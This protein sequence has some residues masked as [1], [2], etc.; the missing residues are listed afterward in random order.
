MATVIG[1]PAP[2]DRVLP[3]CKAGPTLSAGVVAGTRR[4][5]AERADALAD[6][7]NR[8]SQLRGDPFAF[9]AARDAAAREARSLARS[10]RGDGL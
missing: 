2:R 9:H 8:I 7:I 5:Y 6:A 1:A 10:L 4:T 3:S